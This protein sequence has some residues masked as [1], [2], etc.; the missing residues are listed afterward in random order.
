MKS[1]ILYNISDEI[2]VF[3][4]KIKAFNFAKTFG[5][6]KGYNHFCRQLKSG[7]GE[8]FRSKGIKGSLEHSINQKPVE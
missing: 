4:N 8:F 3:S 7:R 5:Y 1:I 2:R 6:D